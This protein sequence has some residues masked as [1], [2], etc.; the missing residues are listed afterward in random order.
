MMVLM[1]LTLSRLP[2]EDTLSLA[3]EHLQSF[4]KPSDIHSSPNVSRFQELQKRFK[5]LMTRL[6]GNQT[7][8]DSNPDLI[9]AV[10]VQILIPKLRLGPGSQVHLYIPRAN[11]TMGLPTV[12][13]L[14]QA[15]LRLS[16]TESSSWDVTRPLQRQLDFGISREPVIRLHLPAPSERL[17]A[18]L[19]SAQ[20]RLELHWWPRAGRGRRSPHARS[21]NRC[22]LGEGRCCRLKNLR[23][24]LH[25]LGWADWVIS[26]RELDL[27][28]CSGACPSQ[29]RS[30][31]MHA[32]M[33]ARLHSLRPEAAPAPC[34]V[35]SSYEP[36]VLMH[37]DSQGRVSLTTYDNL[38]AKDCHCV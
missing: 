11:L 6:Q 12:S 28:M 30:A 17:L 9:P 16:P 8:E 5:D 31:N 10:H 19:P 20:L 13:R 35:P 24:S 22:P 34:C 38:V 33:L 4:P 26:P 14:H 7:W 1:L 29:F 27:R 21:Q 25:D 37:R 36:V 23:A 3:Q 32:Q 18:A 15:L 2:S